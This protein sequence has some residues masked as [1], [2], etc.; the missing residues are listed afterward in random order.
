VLVRPCHS[1]RQAVRVQAQVQKIP[2]LETLPTLEQGYT[3]V[4]VRWADRGLH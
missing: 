2:S 3:Y 4:D 1:R